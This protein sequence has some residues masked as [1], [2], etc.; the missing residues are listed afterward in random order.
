MAGRAP[1]RDEKSS[2]SRWISPGLVRDGEII[3]R[4]IF[5]PHHIQGGA[6]SQAAVSLADIRSRGWS[7]D[8]KKYTSLW[9]VKLS[10]RSWLSKKAD[11]EKCYVIPVSVEKIR[12]DCRMGGDQLFV[13]TD[14]ALC[15]N[16]A[17]GCV[18]LSAES[19]EGQARRARRVLM[20]VLPK[21]VEASRAFSPQDTWGWSRGIL[22]KFIAPMRAIGRIVRASLP[23]L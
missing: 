7:V 14:L 13:V 22:L 12:N 15:G 9:R 18:L 4:T 2:A 19:G 10:H 3:L 11:L 23:F 20:G 16:P 6:L 1:H 17:H 5:D 8:R 21:Y